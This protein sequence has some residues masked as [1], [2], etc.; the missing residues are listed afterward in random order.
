MRT[1][2]LSFFHRIFYFGRGELHF[3]RLSCVRP[4][5]INWRQSVTKL[6]SMPCNQQRTIPPM[7]R[8]HF[9][10]QYARRVM[11]PQFCSKMQTIVPLEI[12]ISEEKK[13]QLGISHQL[14]LRDQSVQDFLRSLHSSSTVFRHPS[15]IL[16]QL[17]CVEQLAIQ[18][19]ILLKC[20]IN[21]ERIYC[22]LNGSL[23]YCQFCLLINTSI[24]IWPVRRPS[25]SF[26]IVFAKNAR[27]HDSDVT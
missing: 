15:A 9:I 3:F 2:L 1:P 4:G 25:S 8:E 12:L 22:A 20:N 18:T 24:G 16:G 23:I 5:H 17:H 19:Y 26:V 6:R 13:S 10:Q 14:H 11:L 21:V 27:Y 7:L